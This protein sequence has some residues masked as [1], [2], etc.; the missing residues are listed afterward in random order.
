MFKGSVVVGIVTLVL[1]STTGNNSLSAAELQSF[2]GLYKLTSGSMTVGELELSLALSETGRYHYLS[3]SRPTGFIGKLAGG[4]IEEESSGKVSANTVQPV[5]YRY[6]REGRKARTVALKFDWNKLKVVNTVNDDPWVMSIEPGTID[7]LA[8]QLLLMR[9]LKAGKRE[10]EYKVADGG[11]LK[12]YRFFRGGD[13]KLNSPLGE[14]ETVR[15]K[16]DRGRK[17]RYM[18]FWCAPSLGYL[19]VRIVQYRDGEE[20]ARMILHRIDPSPQ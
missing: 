3:K 15:V 2:S 17:D 5:N 12:T 1:F 20:H 10:M 13:E 9:D 8:A 6:R 7:K 14:M 16:R 11:T 19:P 4:R 18:E